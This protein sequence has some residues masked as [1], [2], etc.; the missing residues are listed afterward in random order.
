V[1]KTLYT[2]VVT[3]IVMWWLITQ[4][5][6]APLDTLAALRLA[7]IARV[8]IVMEVATVSSPVIAVA[9]ASETATD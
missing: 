6:V 3:A 9:G 2:I 1:I 8:V 7:S 5:G 4:V